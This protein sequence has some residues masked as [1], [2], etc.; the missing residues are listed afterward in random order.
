MPYHHS[1]YGEYAAKVQIHSV[2]VYGEADGGETEEGSCHTRTHPPLLTLH[3][4]ADESFVEQITNARLL[5]SLLRPLFSSGSSGSISIPT[6][7]TGTV[8]YTLMT[9]PLLPLLP[10]LLLP[11][12]LSRLFQGR[13]RGLGWG[14]S[15][16]VHHEGN[17]PTVLMEGTLEV[18]EVIQLVERNLVERGLGEYYVWEGGM[19]SI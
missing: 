17:R 4:K 8:A 16:V 19:S 13:S 9:C 3:V 5:P 11:V 12:H 7:I 2:R 18:R 14:A 1:A 15:Q 6:G 10:L